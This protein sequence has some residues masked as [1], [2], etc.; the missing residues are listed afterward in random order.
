M[1]LGPVI[2]YAADRVRHATLTL[3]GRRYLAKNPIK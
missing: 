3:D 1:E 2:P